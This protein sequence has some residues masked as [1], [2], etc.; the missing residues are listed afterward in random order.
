MQTKLSIIIPVLNEAGTLPRT[1]T[2]IQDLRKEGHELIVVDG[3]STDGSPAV[4]RPFADLVL[5]S[6]RGRA[7]Q[8][9]AGAGAGRGDVLLFLHAD[10]LLPGGAP[11]WILEGL[12]QEKACWGRFDIRLSGRHVLFRLIE[13][14]M[15]LRSRLT[16]I[17]T[18]DQALFVRRTVFRAVKGFPEIDLMEDIALSRRL[19][20]E[21]R[22]LCLRQK[23]ETSSRRW[24]EKGIFRTVLLMWRLRFLYWFGVAPERLVKWYR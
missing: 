5:E 11:K 14:L 9:N 10:T 4:A 8:M 18:G 12:E 17:A 22:P 24:E 21:G 2:P 1:L 7:R 16:G 6:P 15:N 3:G 20:R 13:G 23:V 19:K